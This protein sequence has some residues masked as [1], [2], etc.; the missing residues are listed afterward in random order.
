MTTRQQ[1]HNM[2]ARLLLLLSHGPHCSTVLTRS[3]LFAALLAV[4]KHC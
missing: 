1:Q 2:G 3:L 4:L